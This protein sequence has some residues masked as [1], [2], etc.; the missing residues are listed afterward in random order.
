M[1]LLVRLKE[2]GMQQPACALLLSPWADM[3]ATADSY[4]RNAK[5]DPVL[6]RELMQF[7]AEQYLV[8]RPR[9][10]PLASPVFADL[11]GIAPL[12]EA[13]GVPSGRS[14]WRRTPPR[15]RG[16]IGPQQIAQRA[17]PPAAGA[18]SARRR[19]A[20]T[21]RGARATRTRRVASSRFQWLS[22]C[23]VAA[24][25]SMICRIS[26]RWVSMRSSHAE[27]AS[28]SSTAVHRRCG[29]W[30]AERQGWRGSGCVRCAA[31]RGGCRR[32]DALARRTRRAL[33]ARASRGGGR[34]HPA[35]A[36][37]KDPATRAC[38]DGRGSKGLVCRAFE[39]DHTV[40]RGRAR[41]NVL[42]WSAM[43]PTF[44]SAR[45]WPS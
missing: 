23:C 9:E 6:N 8:K 14:S 19:S 30:P 12:T 7:L 10:T 28:A 3:T 37:R 18:S 45:S 11:S 34:S 31:G 15:R 4:R 22:S 17:P 44:I 25:P 43:K 33:Q 41:L 36:G 21:R 5:R 38:R 32:A 1:A 2:L 26:T 27:R 35:L 40:P 24:R 29:D 42:Q 20:P 16:E 39:A 13:S